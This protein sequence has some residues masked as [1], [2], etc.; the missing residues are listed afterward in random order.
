[1]I[2]IGDRDRGIT[3]LRERLVLDEPV[4]LGDR[5]F[6]AAALLGSVFHNVVQRVIDSAGGAPSTIGIVVGGEASP[7]VRAAVERAT[8]YAGLLAPSINFYR[9]SFAAYFSTW[10][11]ALGEL[12]SLAVCEADFRYCSAGVLVSRSDHFSPNGG[13]S[14]FFSWATRKVGDVHDLG[15]TIAAALDAAAAESDMDLRQVDAI[16]LI[17]EHPAMSLLALD[18]ESRIGRAVTMG[19]EL[20]DAAAIGAAS[21]ARQA[22]GQTAQ[23]ASAVSDRYRSLPASPANHASKPATIFGA[24][25]LDRESPSPTLG[26]T[27]LP[28]GPAPVGSGN[29]LGP[30]NLSIARE[31]VDGSV[32]VVVSASANTVDEPLVRSASSPP[33]VR[34]SPGSAGDSPDPEPSVSDGALAPVWPEKPGSPAISRIPGS[35][36]P[37]LNAEL[38]RDRFSQEGAPGVAA[39][40]GRSSRRTALIVGV[41]AALVLV[42]GLIGL[43]RWSPGAGAQLSVSRTEVRDGETYMINLSGFEPSEPIRFT[44]TGPTHG[45][46]APV[47]ADG[48][49]GGVNGPVFE[50]DPPGEYVITA[51]GQLSG[52]TAT[53]SV[54]VTP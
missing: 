20:R 32:S 22:V 41:A 13:H 3:G 30:R 4:R 18:L 21:L 40:R 53:V 17:G 46:M 34:I 44:W 5:S 39:R 31:P 11:R 24:P 35:G 36:Q 1:M 38:A 14:P 43:S 42:C 6:E 12:R 37:I 48:M 29:A 8:R 2:G 49:G 7:I 15:S 28:S 19:D 9:D 52:R 27:T 26:V 10:P 51:T 54:R 16:W 25:G 33:A 47:T 45:E 23:S 50:Q